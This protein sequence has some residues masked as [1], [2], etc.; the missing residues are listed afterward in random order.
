MP[1]LCNCNCVPI[2]LV[3]PMYNFNA[4]LIDAK[5]TVFWVY[6]CYE[7]IIIYTIYMFAI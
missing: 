5:Q 7:L 1:S 4:N 2:F 6:W 3:V